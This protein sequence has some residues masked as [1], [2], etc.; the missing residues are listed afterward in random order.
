MSESRWK[1]FS[2]LGIR[3]RNKFWQHAELKEGHPNYAA[4]WYLVFL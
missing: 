1:Q 4:H 3:L 2:T